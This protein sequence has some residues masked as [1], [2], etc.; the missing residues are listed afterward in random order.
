MT[1]SRTPASHGWWRT[2][3]F[4]GLAAAFTAAAGLVMFSA[5]MYYDDEGYVLISL[6][7]FAEHGSL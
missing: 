3:V 2:L 6:R 1:E 5:F 4:T 7:S